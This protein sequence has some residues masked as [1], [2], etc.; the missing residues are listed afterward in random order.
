MNKT[1]RAVAG[2]FHKGMFP[3]LRGISLTPEP[4]ACALYTVQDMLMKDHNTL[5]PVR[6]PPLG[7]ATIN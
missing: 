3:K 4:E 2:A 6:L 1:F 5:I 7:N